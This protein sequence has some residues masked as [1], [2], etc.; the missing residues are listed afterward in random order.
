MRSS[1]GRHMPDA[2]DEDLVNAAI[3]MIGTLAT[4]SVPDEPRIQLEVI[5]LGAV[6]HAIH[7]LG[8][9][10]GEAYRSL[11]WLLDELRLKSADDAPKLTLVP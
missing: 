1:Y 8:M 7:Q 4:R 10:C 6:S 9:P 2:Y 5:L 11:S 3:S